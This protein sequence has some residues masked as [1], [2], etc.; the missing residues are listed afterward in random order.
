LTIEIRRAIT[1]DAP[2]ILRLKLA[3]WPSEKLKGVA[4]ISEVIQQPDHAT[5]IAFVEGVPAGF[6]DGFITYSIEGLSRWEV[7]LLAVHPDFR[8]KGIAAQLVELSTGAGR[9]MGAKSARGLVEIENIA[10]QRTFAR[11]GYE[12]DNQVRALHIS[13]ELVEGAYPLPENAHLINVNTIN[14]QGVWLEGQFSENAFWAGQA[15]RTQQGWDLT[16]A[17]IP[18]N[19]PTAIETAQVTGFILIGE[20]QWWT[21]GL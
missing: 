10:S 3:T 14:Y 11:C 15:H 17:V 13:S 9:E 8:G 4:S 21:R 7:D 16:G 5:F 2:D 19:E 12:L 1:Q 6:V 18:S 20:Y